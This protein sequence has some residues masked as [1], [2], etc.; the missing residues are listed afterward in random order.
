MQKNSVR[1]LCEAGVIAALY[2]ALTVLMQPIAFGPVQVRLSEALTILPVG[3]PSAVGGLSVGCALSNLL[4]IATNPAGAWDVLFGTA[5]T[6][7]A[8]LCTRALRRVR[9]FGLPIAATLPPVLFNAVVVGLELSMVY[10]D[11]SWG[12]FALCAVQVAAGE[13]LS[14]T[15]AGLLL[16]RFMPKKLFER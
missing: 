7:A 9:W 13:L 4:C 8:A 12:T 14:A 15:L 3:M 5:A 1:R 16:W 2:T 10:F 6:L 11:F